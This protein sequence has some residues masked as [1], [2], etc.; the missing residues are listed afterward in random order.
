MSNNTYM[1]GIPIFACSGRYDFLGS[2]PYVHDE[3]LLY[4]GLGISTNSMKCKFCDS[5]ITIIKNQRNRCENCGAS[6]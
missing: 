4:E 6:Y 3:D 5:T 2:S 1:S